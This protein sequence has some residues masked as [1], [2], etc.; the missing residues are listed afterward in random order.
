[1][2]W[3]YIILGSIAILAVLQIGLADSITTSIACDGA[4]FLTTAIV[5]P[6][7]TYS[8]VLFTDS[9]A[10]VTRVVDRGSEIESTSRITGSGAFGVDEFIGKERNPDLDNRYCVFVGKTNKSDYNSVA[11]TGLFW[12]GSYLGKKKVGNDSTISRTAIN[13][14]GMVLITSRGDDGNTSTNAKTFAAG[15]MELSEEVLFGGDTNA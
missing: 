15:P 1:M 11:T 8:N 13:G 9:Q 5:G 10:N 3:T 14:T 7:E 2:K 12:S 6:E 4:A